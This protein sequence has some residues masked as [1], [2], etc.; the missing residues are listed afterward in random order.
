MN[1]YCNHINFKMFPLKH[2]DFDWNPRSNPTV[3]DIPVD[4]V[5]PEL[6]KIIN[7]L[8]VYVSWIQ[9]FYRPKNDFC[10]H[11]M[12][13]RGGDYIKINWAFRG[14]GSRMTWYSVNPAANIDYANAIHT[15]EANSE[16]IVYKTGDLILE[17]TAEIVEGIPAIVQV[18]IPHHIDNQ[19]DQRYCIAFSINDIKTHRRL[20]MQQA[21]DI[22][23]DYL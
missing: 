7:D 15:T 10:S 14:V 8:G 19:I 11:H 3:S 21:I 2:F 5:N 4:Q 13:N 16:Y 12:D 6:N 1:K 9:I 22:F 23:K 20:T 18:G 17:H